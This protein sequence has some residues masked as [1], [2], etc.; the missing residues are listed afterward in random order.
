MLLRPHFLRH[1]P[2]ASSLRRP[3][4]R[5]R[6][7]RRRGRLS[8][9]TAAIPSLEREEQ[10]RVGDLLRTAEAAGTIYAAWFLFSSQSSER[11]L[12]PLSWTLSRQ[13]G[14][15]A[16]SMSGMTSRS[17]CLS[18]RGDPGQDR[19]GDSVRL[20]RE[21]GVSRVL[22]QGG[23]DPIAQLVGELPPTELRLERIA[24][25]NDFEQRRVAA[26][27]VLPDGCRFDR[28]ALH[29]QRLGIPTREP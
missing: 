26:G 13:G 18:K 24:A 14:Q 25:R 28:S 10:D 29:S 21:Q 22:D 16:R 11:L 6:A 7:F 27:P 2:R 3:R 12:N 5:R 4:D 1:R 23:R 8:A 15:P 9:L 19:L 20:L 17:A